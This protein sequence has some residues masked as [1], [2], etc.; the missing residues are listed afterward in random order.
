M[1]RQL[2]EDEFSAIEDA[3]ANAGCTGVR[4]GYGGRA[5]FGETCVAID[6][7]RPGTVAKA[8]TGLAQTHPDLAD[9]LADFRSDSMG[10]DMIAYW[11]GVTVAGKE[12]RD[13]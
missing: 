10:L 9:E 12:A 7:D 5:M 1:K 3:A 13:G 11:P 2:T 4:R 8:L 6:A